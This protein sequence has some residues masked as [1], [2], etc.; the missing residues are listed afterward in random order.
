VP[1]ARYPYGPT[2]CA[3][4]TSLSLCSRPHLPHQREGRRRRWKRRRWCQGKSAA[5][6]QI[7]GAPCSLLAVSPTSSWRRRRRRA[8]RYRRPW[9]S[10][11]VRARREAANAPAASCISSVRRPRQSRPAATTHL[12]APADAAASCSTAFG[13][14]RV[15]C[16]SYIVELVDLRINLDLV[17]F[18]SAIQQFE[19][20]ALLP[21]RYSAP[22][23]LLPDSHG[24]RRHSLLRDPTSTA[25][26]RP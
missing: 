6:R 19:A 18:D 14:C 24:L 2:S 17:N 21:S 23:Q 20:L 11:A 25:H 26:P 3:V 1:S 15:Q 9:S 13:A 7:G 16:G 4:S 10:A 12:E 5:A 22:S 8:W